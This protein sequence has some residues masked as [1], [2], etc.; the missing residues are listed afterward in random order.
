MLVAITSIKLPGIGLGVRGT[1]MLRAGQ[2]I[3]DSVSSALLAELVAQGL[4]V[5]QKPELPVEPRV[6]H[7][8]K[9]N[10]DPARLAGKSAEELRTLVCSID[11]TIEPADLAAHAEA[12]IVQMLTSEF[13][14]A[15]PAPALSVSTDRTRPSDAA[16]E[17][18]RRRAKG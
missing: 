15:A 8:G 17:R 7:Q 16:L 18:A 11:P 1:K 9:W 3:P 6:R 5:E 12:E 4:V 14:P 2:P 10:M 13:D